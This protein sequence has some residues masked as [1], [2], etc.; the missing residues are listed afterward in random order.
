M[1]GVNVHMRLTGRFQSGPEAQDVPQMT[2]LSSQVTQFHWV[3]TALF[4]SQ[5]ENYPLWNIFPVGSKHLGAHVKFHKQHLLN[6]PN[7]FKS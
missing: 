4:I 5:F 2:N 7:V 3:E 1:C 6:L